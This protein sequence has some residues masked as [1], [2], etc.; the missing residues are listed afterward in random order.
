M[1]LIKELT[2]NLNQLR[3]QKR[4]SKNCYMICI[5]RQRISDA[6]IGC[7]LSGG[8]DS[9]MITYLAAKKK[10]MPL[11]DSVSIIF[12]GNEKDYSEEKFMNIVGDKLGLNSHQKVI[13]KDYVL[14]NLEKAVWHADSII[15]RPNL[16]GLMILTE[17]VKKYVTVL[18]SGEGADRGIRNYQ[19]VEM[20][21]LNIKN[22]NWEESELLWKMIN[23]EI[24]SQ[25]FIDKR[26][27][28]E[29]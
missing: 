1:I 25:L 3:M 16:V 2:E 5:R 13:N 24:W 22:L 28:G 11:K 8:V 9:S 7:Q 6:S 20:Q 17:E 15:G 27:Y 29:Y 12:D 18:S 4:S 10:I 14:K 26:K 19:E 21:Y 23:F